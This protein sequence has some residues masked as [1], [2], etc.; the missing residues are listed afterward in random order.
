MTVIWLSTSKN[1]RSKVVANEIKKVKAANDY[2][3]ETE[4]QSPRKK[5]NFLEG[6]P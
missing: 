2:Q 6:H 1:H 3:A 4:N 5:A